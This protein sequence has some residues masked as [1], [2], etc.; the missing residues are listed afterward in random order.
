MWPKD[1]FKQHGRIPAPEDCYV[2]ISDIMGSTAAIH[3]GKQKIVNMLGAACIAAVRNHFPI[4]EIKYVFGGDGATFLVPS[5]HLK[6]LKDILRP[7]QAMALLSFELKLR[8]GEVSVAELL[9]A[10]APL[11]LEELE[12]GDQ[13]KFYLFYGPGFSLADKWIKERY[14]EETGQISNDV[15][16]MNLSGLSCRLEPFLSQFGSIYSF[17]IESRLPPEEEIDLHQRLF[18]ILTKEG[19]MERLRPLQL[20]NARRKWLHKTWA[21]EARLH[22]TGIG[23]LETG[24]NYLNSIFASFM[25]KFIFNFNIH[26]QMTGIPAEYMGDLVRQSD[27]FKSCGSL[28]L[29]LDLPNHLADQFIQEIQNLED[30]GDLY[31]GIQK[32]SAALVI[33]HLS[34]NSNKNHFHFIDGSDGGLTFASKQIKQKK[35]PSFV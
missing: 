7:V 34:S 11:W 2:L 12:Y 19:A 23:L 26:N 35:R 13:E 17:I 22:R 28:S 31:Y 25:T 33:C 10:N 16:Q 29:I 14:I 30:K 9:E 8:V 32:G 18:K 3:A 1:N 6:N 24:K 20:A 15:S 27:W 21:I 5:R 4:G